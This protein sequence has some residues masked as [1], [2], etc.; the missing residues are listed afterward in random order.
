MSK[1]NNT[2]HVT[3][4]DAADELDISVEL[5]RD[6]IIR[7]CPHIK[8]GTGKSNLVDPAAVVAWMKENNLTGNPGR[9]MEFSPALQAARLRKE[10]ALA[11]KYELQLQIERGELTP[12]EDYKRWITEHIGG[13]R[14]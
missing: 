11:A 12:T 7:G 2:N 8:G 3:V 1:H 10:N 14:N 4:R 6:Y 13:A 5:L 9:P